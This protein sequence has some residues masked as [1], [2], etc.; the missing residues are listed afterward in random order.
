M[1]HPMA[2]ESDGHGPGDTD[3]ATH[4]TSRDKRQ[5]NLLVEAKEPLKNSALRQIRAPHSAE[6]NEIQAR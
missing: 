1:R 2:L 6:M 5:G 4:C 3:Q